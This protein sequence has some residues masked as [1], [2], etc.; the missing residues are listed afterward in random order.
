MFENKYPYTDF[1][2]LNLDWF[3][4]EFKKVLDDQAT[5][6]G[7]VQTLEET[8]TQFTDFVTNYFDNLDVQQQVNIKLDAMAADGSLM[9]AIAPLFSDYQT[10]ISVLGARIDAF[11]ALPDGSTTADAELIDIRVGNTGYTYPSAGDA[12]RGQIN[13]VEESI[14]LLAANLFDTEAVILPAETAGLHS[15]IGLNNGSGIFTGTHNV[16]QLLKMKQGTF[17]AGAIAIL[18]QGDEITVYG[19]NTGIMLFD[20]V[21]GVV[22]TGA[23][24]AVQDCY[25]PTHRYTISSYNMSGTI[26]PFAIRGRGSGTGASVNNN[27]AILDVDPD[28]CG[29]IYL[30]LNANINYLGRMKIAVLPYEAT[31]SDPYRQETSDVKSIY[32]NGIYDITGY[33]WSDGSPTVTKLTPKT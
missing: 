4:S 18:V 1:S 28:T 5:L 12:V 13:D 10:Q 7:K 15:V 3:L 31:S 14:N 17:T 23:E 2:E 30:Y 6:T 26:C 32:K 11:E 29:G 20:L 21:N 19:T 8:V 33:T 16:A 27:V 25:L 24:I 22:A 9:A